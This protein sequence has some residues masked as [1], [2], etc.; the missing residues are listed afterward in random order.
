MVEWNKW[1]R[2]HDARDPTY[3]YVHS[4][5]KLWLPVQIANLSRRGVPEQNN[6]VLQ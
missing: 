6:F 3:P 2:L 5:R 4:A 1:M